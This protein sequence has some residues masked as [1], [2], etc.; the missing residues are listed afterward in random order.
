MTA[1]Q[2]GDRVRLI[3]TSDQYTRLRPGALGTVRRIDDIGTVHINWDDDGLL[4]LLPDEDEFE[5]MATA[6]LRPEQP[7][8]P[9]CG[10]V[11]S[12]RE[13]DEQGMCNECQR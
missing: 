5:V 7:R 6:R 2:P 3:R 4:G 1:A 11:M 8:C 13:A 9:R 12:F 10:L